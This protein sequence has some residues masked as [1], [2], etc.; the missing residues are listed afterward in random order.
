M[1]REYFKNDYL[2]TIIFTEI[3]KKKKYF[4][5]TIIR[6]NYSGNYLRSILPKIRKKLEMRIKYSIL[7]FNC[8]FLSYSVKIVKKLAEKTCIHC[9][10]FSE[11]LCNFYLWTQTY[12]STTSL[13]Q[14]PDKYQKFKIKLKNYNIRIKIS[15]LIK[16]LT[17]FLSCKGPSKIAKNVQQFGK[18]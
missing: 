5:N 7:N 1:Y 12:L 18:F 3:S 10:I 6:K 11:F 13:S 17:Y 14:I 2:L 9:L 8:K 4:W 16:H 15:T